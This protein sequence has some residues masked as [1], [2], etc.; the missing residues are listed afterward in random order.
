M[1][2]S[3]IL[4]PIVI[5]AVAGVATAVLVR[6]RPEVD[7][8]PPEILAPLVRVRTVEPVD[9]RFDVHAQ[10]T[11]LPRTDTLLVAQVAGQV[12]EVSPAFEPG[13]FFDRG[14]VLVTLDDRDYRLALRRAEAQVAQAEVRLAQQEA[15]AE[16]AA[17]E[18]RQLGD[19]ADPSPLTLREPQVAE[20]KAALAAAEADLEKARIDLERTRIRA[21]F[22]GRVRS[23]RVDLGQ[24]LA[25]GTPVAAVHAVDYAEVRLP[26]PDDQLAYLDLPFAYRDADAPE[27]P[28]VTL[29][30]SFA[31]E[32]HRWQGRIVRTEGEIDPTSR[33]LYLVARVEDPYDRDGGKP[34][35]QVGLF[36]D[37]DVHGRVGEDVV[38]LPRVALRDRDVES[39]GGGRHDGRVLVVDAE[40]RLRYRP[41]EVARVEGERVVIAGG[42]EAGE[43]VCVSPLEVVVDGM[44]VRTV[45]DD[46]GE[47]AD[48]TAAP[49]NP[50]TT[51]EAPSEEVTE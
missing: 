22:A 4:I 13:G 20:A 15:E 21:P 25:P 28:P 23:K 48:P 42:L 33:M 24:Y 51:A 45:E 11:V 6:T 27:G 12:T 41:V 34:P 18:W 14:E 2:L 9:L 36:V 40:D 47:L 1:K 19:G 37:A 38:I 26:V 17:E 31:G 8:R 49:E 30:A 43:R 35:F 3:K 32:R 7:T 5:V 46:P 29:Q 44:K 10:G 16:L 50:R 39:D